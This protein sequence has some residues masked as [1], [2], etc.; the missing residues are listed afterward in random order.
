LYVDIPPKGREEA[1]RQWW[2]TSPDQI[3][4][5]D[6]DEDWAKIEER[7]GWIALKTKLD[8]FPVWIR[9]DDLKRSSARRRARPRHRLPRSPCPSTCTS[10]WGGKGRSR[11]RRASRRTS[12]SSVSGPTTSRS[13]GPVTA[14]RCT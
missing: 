4:F 10:T 8:P 7:N 9:V 1:Y 12:R 5:P 11:R 14:R 2:A 6:S 3:E 13:P